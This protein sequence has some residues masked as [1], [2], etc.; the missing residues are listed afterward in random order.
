M[1]IKERTDK[2]DY[3]KIKSSSKGTVNKMKASPRQAEYTC[4][5]SIL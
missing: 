1:I 3:I 4:K 2:L 5:I